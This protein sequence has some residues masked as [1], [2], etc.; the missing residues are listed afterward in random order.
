M[1]GVTDLE[2]STLRDLNATSID[3]AM[4]L[5]CWIFSFGVGRLGSAPSLTQ[6]EPSL[7]VESL[8]ELRMLKAIVLQ[9][10]HC[11]YS[12][13]SSST[14]WAVAQKSANEVRAIN[15]EYGGQRVESGRGCCSH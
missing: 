6:L 3:W 14:W 4:A 5:N 1:T 9:P 11:H 12:H 2:L 15:Q 13:S 7:N 10:D 8:F